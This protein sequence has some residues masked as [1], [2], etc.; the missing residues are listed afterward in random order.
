[1]SDEKKSD[2]P[3]DP[4]SLVENAFLLGIGVLEMTKEK[5]QGLTSDLIEKG[6]MSKSDA[7]KVTDQITEIAEAQ[8]ETMR[9]T[10]AEETAKAVKASGGVTRDDYDSLKKEL[11]EIKALLKAQGGAAAAGPA[12]E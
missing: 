11:D 2:I 10:V 3:V 9:K 4:A 12:A 5:T 8:Q 6:K 7:K 1:M